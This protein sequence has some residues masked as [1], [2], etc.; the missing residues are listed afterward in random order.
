M[1]IIK[2]ILFLI[3]IVLCNNIYSKDIDIFNKKEVRTANLKDFTAANKY[4]NIANE[5]TNAGQLN[6]AKDSYIKALQTAT[7]PEWYYKLGSVLFD[8]K[9]YKNSEKAFSLSGDFGYKRKDY[10]YYNAACAAS[11]NKS[12]YLSLLNL[13]LALINGYNHWDYLNTDNDIKYLR[14]QKGFSEL[15]NRYNLPET[16]KDPFNDFKHIKN[17]NISSL[18]IDLNDDKV[19]ELLLLFKFSSSYAYE[20]EGSYYFALYNKL[21]SNW[22]FQNITTSNI[23]ST[24]KNLD[25]EN[26]IIQ[27]IN[28]QKGNELLIRSFGRTYHASKI[29]TVAD[30]KLHEAGEIE[31]FYSIKELKGKTVMIGNSITDFAYNNNE[32]E[33]YYQYILK[34]ASLYKDELDETIINEL[35]LSKKRRF[36]DTPNISTASSYYWFTYNYLKNSINEQWID[37]IKNVQYFEYKNELLTII[38]AKYKLQFHNVY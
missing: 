8:L 28:S 3:L 2:K 22:K 27:N 4:I 11:L 37:T 29:L 17:L 6:E 31:G 26:I 24:P 35:Y 14:E 15:I 1:Q 10:S 33:I 12:S 32:S 25:K 34:K 19:N 30:N 13:E 18:E 38:N 7:D 16:I 23:I 36:L 20:M 9:D 21:G 5:N